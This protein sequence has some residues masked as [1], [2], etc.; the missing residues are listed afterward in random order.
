MTERYMSP[1]NRAKKPIAIAAAVLAGGLAINGCGGGGDEIFSFK[2]QCDQSR[3][4]HALKTEQPISNTEGVGTIKVT[5]ENRKGNR[6]APRSIQ[7]AELSD[8]NVIPGNTILNVKVNEGGSAPFSDEASAEIEV[9]ADPDSQKF[10]LITFPGIDE[11]IE[12]YEKREIGVNPNSSVP[13][14]RYP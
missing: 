1:L 7:L 9:D 5:C 13:I 4:L 10:S 2:F 12:I 8:G 6:R 3:S 11:I 14:R